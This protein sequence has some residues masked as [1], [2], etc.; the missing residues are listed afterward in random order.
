MVPRIVAAPS[1]GE[2]LKRSAVYG[3]DEGSNIVRRIFRASDLFK[4]KAHMPKACNTKPLQA[5]RH[6]EPEILK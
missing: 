6:G 4:T 5:L 1:M 2:N 3:A